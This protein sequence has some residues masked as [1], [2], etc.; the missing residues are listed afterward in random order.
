MFV[1]HWYDCIHCVAKSC[2]TTA[3]RCLLRDSLSSL[4]ILCSAVIKSPKFS[5]L[6]RTV[7]ARFLQEALVI[8]SSSRYCKLGPS[9][10]ARRHCACPNL[11]PLLLATPLVIH[12]KN[13]KCLDPQ[14]SGL[15]V[16]LL[17]HFH[18]PNSL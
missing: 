3:Y 7:S 1:L 14:A 18:Q 15:L 16:A 8:L 17:E 9:G 10:S 2:T 5:A 13:W 6:G 11:V 4:R 12:E